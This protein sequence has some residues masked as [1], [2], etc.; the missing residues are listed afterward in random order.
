LEETSKTGKFVKSVATNAAQ[1]V[2]AAGQMVMH[3]I[4]TVTGLP[5][6]VGRLFDRVGTGVGNL[7]DA[8]A[9]PNESELKQAG[10][11]TR[12]VLGYEQERRALPRSWGSTRTPP[13]Q[14][15]RKSWATSLGCHL[16]GVWG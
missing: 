12:D 3:P 14:C 11:A 1:T 15:L 7:W 10:A 2:K 13:I 9:D 5:S 4:D 8:A 16:P 6:G